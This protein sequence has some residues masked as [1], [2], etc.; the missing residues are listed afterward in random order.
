MMIFRIP[1]SLF[2]VTTGIFKIVGSFFSFS[3]IGYF[4]LSKFGDFF[5]TLYNIPFLRWSDFYY[6]NVMGSFIVGSLL[7]L[8]SLITFILSLEDIKNL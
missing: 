1:F 4:V 8:V 3:E 2:L 7:F 6:T 5:S